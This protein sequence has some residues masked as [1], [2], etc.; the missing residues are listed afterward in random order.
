M[1]VDSAC[2]DSPCFAYRQPISTNVCQFEFGDLGKMKCLVVIAHPLQKSLCHA[3]EGTVVAALEESGHSVIVQNLYEENFNACLTVNERQTYYSEIYDKESISKEIQWLTSAELLV[4]VFPTWWFGFPAI[5]KGW[6]DRV[7]APG[8]AY[9]HA[10]DFGPIKPRLSN[11]R[12]TI[13]VTTLGAQWWVDLFIMG[14]PVR[15]VLKRAILGAC[16]PSS[17]FKMVSLYGA[18]RLDDKTVTGFCSKVRQIIMR[19]C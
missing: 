13:A 18:E 19:F 8:V 3:L 17:Q 4:L 2:S 10:P 5:L 7:W 6:F 15:K 12:S 16:A 14:R 9:D 11:L 1:P